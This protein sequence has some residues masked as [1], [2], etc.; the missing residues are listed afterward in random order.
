MRG[1]A[2]VSILDAPQIFT[3]IG[4]GSN[5][6]LFSGFFGVAKVIACGTFVLFLVER[7]G[8]RFALVGGAFFMGSLMLI[9]SMLVKASP[10][11]ATGPITSSAIAAVT[12]VYLEASKWFT[13]L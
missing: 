11:N 13:Y 7:I 6:L 4:A 8:R 2:D 10:P 9:V 1:S 5:N 12:M 3:A